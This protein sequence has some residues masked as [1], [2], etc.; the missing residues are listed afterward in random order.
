M[1]KLDG[2]VVADCG[3][4]GPLL[5]IST[6]D[7]YAIHLY[8]APVF[9]NRTRVKAPQ[10]VNSR[11]TGERINGVEANEDNF[12]VRFESGIV[13][14]VASSK[15]ETARVFKKG[16]GRHWIYKAGALK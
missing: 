14:K 10:N 9:L 3:W 16:V 11:L 2:K 4:A 7:N 5:W 13:L 15:V 8:D 12:S 1:I 6:T